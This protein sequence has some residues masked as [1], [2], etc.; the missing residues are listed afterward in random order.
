[1]LLC[2]RVIEEGWSRAQAAA[3]AGISE[4]TAAK[5]LARYRAEGADGLIDR[6]STPLT[7]PTRVPEERLVRTSQPPLRQLA[8][9]RPVGGRDPSWGGS[10]LSADSTEVAVF[11]DNDDSIRH[12]FSI[13]TLEVNLEVPGGKATRVEFI[14]E[15]GTYEFY[16]AVPGHE[17]MRGELVV[18]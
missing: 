8:A 12:T 13:D 7:S 3:A 15:P 18:R 17:D 6:P 9:G 1:L 14:A 16:C 4:R 10:N 2:R 11:V 5:W